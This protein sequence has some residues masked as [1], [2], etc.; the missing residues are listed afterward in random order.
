MT[1]GNGADMIIGGDGTDTLTGGRGA[2][3][4]TG[5]NNADTFVI[6]AGDSTL[7]TEDTIT[8]FTTTV[9]KIEFGGPKAVDGTNYNEALGTANT[10]AIFI[11]NANTYF[12]G[13][14]QYYVEYDL[15][16]SGNAYLAYDG[17]KDGTLDEVVILNGVNTAAM[18]EA[19]DII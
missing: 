17:D 16:G 4:L 13:T 2:D 18:I 8:D 12:D 19:G 9:D 15:A 11:T 10:V 1:G 5:G 7:T 14:T 3:I 6:G